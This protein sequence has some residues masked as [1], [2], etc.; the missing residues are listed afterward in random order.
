MWH[1]CCTYLM[2]P[3]RTYEWVMSHIYRN[4]LTHEYYGDSYVTHTHM[5]PRN[6]WIGTYI[7][8]AICICI[9]IADSH[10]FE[11][12]GWVY[13]FWLCM[14]TYGYQIT[15]KPPNPTSGN[16]I[17][18]IWLWTHLE[19]PTPYICIYVYIYIF[20]FI[21][22]WISTHLESP[23]PYIIWLLSLLHVL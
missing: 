19:P 16:H 8:L 5:N 9:H 23:E 17:I 3:C 13:I 20:T 10:T 18:R 1:S 7:F 22:M 14:L 2:E 6:I 15:W 21:K 11:V 4:M 12:E